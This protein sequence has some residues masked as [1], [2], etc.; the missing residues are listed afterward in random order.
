MAAQIAQIFRGVAPGTIT[1]ERPTALELALNP[2][3]AKT[4]GLKIPEALL[5]TAGEVV[6]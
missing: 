5:A 6:E 1:I 4:L 3:I 2:G